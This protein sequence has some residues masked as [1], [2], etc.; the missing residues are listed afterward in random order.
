MFEPGTI[1]IRSEPPTTE[2][3][4]PDEEVTPVGRPGAIARAT[5]AEGADDAKKENPLEEAASGATDAAAAEGVDMNEKEDE[6]A[7]GAP[8]GD[9]WAGTADELLRKLKPEEGFDVVVG[10]A[11]EALDDELSDIPL[12]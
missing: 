8:G 10:A 1:E 4:S 11:D 7:E 3:G 6:T 12:H 2:D 9:G 5:E